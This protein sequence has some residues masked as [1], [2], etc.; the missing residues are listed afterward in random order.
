MLNLATTDA[1]QCYADTVFTRYIVSQIANSNRVDLVWD[2][3]LPDSLKA[4]TQKRGKGMQRRVV[5]S[6]KISKNWK[7]ILSVDKTKQNFSASCH[8][9]LSVSQLAVTK[10]YMYRYIRGAVKRQCTLYLVVATTYKFGG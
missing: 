3:Y 10:R 8:V 9:E 1:F 5:L 4:T 7:D 2:V 6:T